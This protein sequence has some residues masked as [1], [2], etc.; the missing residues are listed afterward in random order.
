MVFCFA[1]SLSLHH[2]SPSVHQLQHITFGWDKI[3]SFAEKTNWT[4][5]LLSSLTCACFN[6]N[7]PQ[8][9]HTLHSALK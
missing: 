3:P 7:F 6:F 4:A 2:L 1:V 5:P 8:T 9:F